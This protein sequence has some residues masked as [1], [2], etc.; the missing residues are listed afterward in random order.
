MSAQ[1]TI[2]GSLHDKIRYIRDPFPLLRTNQPTKLI[3]GYQKWEGQ[4]PWQTLVAPSLR[5][6]VCLSFEKQPHPKM[7]ITV[8]SRWFRGFDRL[9][10]VKA[11]RWSNN[12]P[13]KWRTSTTPCLGLHMTT[14]NF[15]TVVWLS[16]FAICC[17]LVKY[18]WIWSNIGSHTQSLTWSFETLPGSQ[19]VKVVCQLPTIIVYRGYVKLQEV[20]LRFLDCN[21][22]FVFHSGSAPAGWVQEFKSISGDQRCRNWLSRSWWVVMGS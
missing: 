19:K 8:N 7:T 16:F 1:S 10:P 6:L 17:S 11:P 3:K 9:K 13:E 18:R 21:P 12:S 4:L 22:F 20:Y 14:T 2:G 15:K 5:L